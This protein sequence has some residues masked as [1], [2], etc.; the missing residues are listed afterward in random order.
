MKNAWS[1]Y[2]TIISCLLLSWPAIASDQKMNITLEINGEKLQATLSDNATAKSF[3]DLLPLNLDVRDYA[4]TEKASNALPKKLST[5]SAPKGYKAKTG[6]LTYYALW[7]NLAVFYDADSYA[8]NLIYM[9]KIHETENL[10]TLKKA[11][12]IKITKGQ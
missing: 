10:S 6:D 2:I 9:G 12:K 3:Y 11:T 8:N 1:A 7:G 5:D 4:G